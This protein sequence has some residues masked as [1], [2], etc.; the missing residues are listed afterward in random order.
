MVAEGG[1]PWRYLT[2]QEWRWN[3]FD[4]LVVIL[5]FAFLELTASYI[6]LLRM[7]SQAREVSID[8]RW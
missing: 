5:S 4:L 3:F 7:V 1:A 6:Y 2:G 8:S